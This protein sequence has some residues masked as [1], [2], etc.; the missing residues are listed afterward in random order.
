[1][2]PTAPPA[3]SSPPAPRTYWHL[4]TDPRGISRQTLCQLAPY[5]LGV[6]GPNDSPQWNL[7]LFEQGNSFLTLL[8]V[9]WSADWHENH[10]PKWIF[11]LRGAWSVQSMDGQR[12]VFGPGDFS[13]GGDQGCIATPEG[14]KGHLS[15]QV[16]EEP[17]LQLIL[18]RND[19]AWR[20]AP[21]GFFS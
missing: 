20:N 13:F 4:W 11:V 3:P 19:D 1:M 7:D 18:Q 5:R 6:L 9:G 15:A 8:P 2:D 17:C 14:A 16:G 12:Q 10:V 21:P